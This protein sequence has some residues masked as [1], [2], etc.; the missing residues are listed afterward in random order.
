MDPL[1]DILSLLKPQSYLTAGLDVGGRWAVDGVA[2]P[3]RLGPGNSPL[4]RKLRR[5]HSL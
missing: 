4:D 2:D 3:I 5:R 1:S